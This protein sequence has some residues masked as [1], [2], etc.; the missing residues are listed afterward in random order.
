MIPILTRLYERNREEFI[1]QSR[2]VLNPAIV[3]SIPFALVMVLRSKAML[4]ALG[5][6]M[7]RG[8]DSFR[9]VAILLVIPGLNM[10]I[11]WLSSYYGMI[12]IATNRINKQAKAAIFAAIFNIVMTIPLVAW[13][14]RHMGNGAIGAA[15][16]AELTDL[17][18]VIFYMVW[19]ADIAPLKENFVALAKGL[20]AGIVPAVVLLYL[21]MHNRW[22]FI[23]VCGVAIALFIP[24]AMLTGAIRKDEITPLLDIIKARARMKTKQ[25]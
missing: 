14:H 18:M 9:A 25:G 4:Y 19:I 2:R 8:A 22:E 23:L 7:S 11:R 15:I 20:V 10:P 6:P 5:L 13:F 24:T 17:L 1:L 3:L 12:L 21:P 16:A